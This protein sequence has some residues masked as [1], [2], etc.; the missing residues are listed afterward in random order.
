[1][2][3][4]FSPAVLVV[5][6]GYFVDIFD[7][8]L[9]N[10]VRVQSLESL[11]VPKEKIIE[12]GI[13]LLNFQ[14]A[15]MLLGG[16]FWGILG[17][18]KGRLNVL[19]ASILLYSAANIANAFVGNIFWYAVLR[20]ISG[21]GLA[22][23]LGAGI[24]LIAELLPKEKRGLGTTLI[25][26]IGVFG[27]TL[28]A[29]IVEHFNWS[30][31]YIIGGSLGLLLLFLRVQVSESPLFKNQKDQFSDK[32]PHIQWGNFLSLFQSKK[33]FLRFYNI[34]IIGVPIWFIAGLVMAFS[35]ELAQEIGVI[36]S[37]SAAKSIGFSYLG[38]GVGDLLS[39]LLSQKLRSR[40]KSI[41]FFLI[42]TVVFLFGL[43]TLTPNRS[44]EFFYVL[45]FFIGVGAGF[46]AI[47]VT[48]AAEQFGTNLR[49]TVATCAP[50]FVRGSV[51]P[52][53]LLFKYLKPQFGIELAM[54]YVGV[55]VFTLALISLFHLEETFHK[56]LTFLE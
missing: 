10:M 32:N 27:A 48:V 30:T 19:F 20:F 56:D 50:N 37:I 16:I 13:L 15:G 8:T 41:L 53:T 22:G 1:M 2:S 18:K 23:E 14:M 12:T 47:F 17:D 3:Y 26:T 35:P 38:L 31:C 28:G 4:L 36:G 44:S 11:M 33:Q 46:W 6:L 24:T 52:M 40:K 49:A 43:F 51:I 55:L 21:L 45:C 34:V 9:F 25:A 5:A 42:I 7:L 29:L 54:I 39:G